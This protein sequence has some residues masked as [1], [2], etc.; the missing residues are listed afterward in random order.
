MDEASG[1]EKKFRVFVADGVDL[2]EIALIMR[3]FVDESAATEDLDVVYKTLEE[4]VVRPALNVCV[5]AE[6]A[7]R[8]DDFRESILEPFRETVRLRCELYDM[9]EVAELR[10]AVAQP[11]RTEAEFRIDGLY[12]VADFLEGIGLVAACVDILDREFARNVP[13]RELFLE[14]VP[15]CL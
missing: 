10:S 6:A 1:S 13:V 3:G 8:P 11:L 14:N 12:M 15:P 4:G 5:V 9:H 7:V 2:R